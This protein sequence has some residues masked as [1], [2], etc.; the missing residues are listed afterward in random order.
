M[1]FISP[2][3]AQSSAFVLIEFIGSLAVWLP[4]AYFLCFFISFSLLTFFF[5]NFAKYALGPMSE[6][7]CL[8]IFSLL[9]PTPMPYLKY[10]IVIWIK[11]NC[12][13]LFADVLTYLQGDLQFSQLKHGV[14]GL[15]YAAINWQLNLFRIMS[16]WWICNNI[17]RYVIFSLLIH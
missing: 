14:R 9:M 5:P 2:N 17:L 10:P 1:N 8:A 7:S 13:R 6:C 3:Y 4:W 11:S 15:H 12:N 16:L